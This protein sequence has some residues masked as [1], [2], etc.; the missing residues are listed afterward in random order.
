MSNAA[1]ILAAVSSLV[2]RDSS[3]GVQWDRTLSAIRAQMEMEMEANRQNDAR[4]EASLDSI[5]DNLPPGTGLPRPVVVQTVAAALSGGN[6]AEQV[7]LAGEI[8]D[9][10]TR[11][12]R[13]VAKKGRSGGLFRVG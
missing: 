8:E 10:L 1:K 9:F 5:Y 3:G 4:I 7:R 6:L 12:P 11:S 2:V 13:F